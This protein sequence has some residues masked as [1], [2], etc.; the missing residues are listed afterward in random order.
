MSKVQK[1]FVRNKLKEQETGNQL[2]SA[3]NLDSQPESEDEMESRDPKAT[4]DSESDEEL[5][6]SFSQLATP[7]IRSPSSVRQL[8]E[9][10]SQSRTLNPKTPQKK[11]K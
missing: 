3:P 9:K 10:I 11:R 6:P 2:S 8:R 7:S 1:N 5:S 4:V